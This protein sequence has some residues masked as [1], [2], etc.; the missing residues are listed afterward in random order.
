M[1]ETFYQ[2]G[3]ERSWKVVRFMVC[4]KTDLRARE[5]PDPDCCVGGPCLITLGTAVHHF[6]NAPRTRRDC[7]LEERCFAPKLGPGGFFT[8][9]LVGDL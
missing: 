9:A 4:P 5:W 2:P 1:A 3:H 8:P 6:T 7:R